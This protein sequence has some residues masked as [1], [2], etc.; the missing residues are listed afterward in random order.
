MNLFVSSSLAARSSWSITSARRRPAARFRALV[1][2]ARAPARLAA[3][4]KWARL[5][6]WA[7]RHGGVRIIERHALPPL[8]LFSLIRFG[9]GEAAAAVADPGAA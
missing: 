1:R 5:V 9:S 7:E 2:A 3:G 8:G 6:Q 4:F